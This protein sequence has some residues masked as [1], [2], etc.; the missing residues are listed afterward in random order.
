MGR[1]DVDLVAVVAQELAEPGLIGD[2][3]RP[4]DLAC[5]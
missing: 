5:R 2:A 4:V 1:E 3:Q